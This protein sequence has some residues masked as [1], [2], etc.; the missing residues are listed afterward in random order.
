MEY[1]NI[2]II[3]NSRANLGSGIC[4]VK[5]T[6]EI[7]EDVLREMVIANIEKKGYWKKQGFWSNEDV[8][9]GTYGG[10]VFNEY[11]Y[12]QFPVTIEHI[13]NYTAE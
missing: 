13:I 9:G 1:K 7:K 2:L 4:F 8:C 3:S 10:Y 12:P 11:D 6:D 5:S